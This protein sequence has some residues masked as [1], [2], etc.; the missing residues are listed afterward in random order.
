MSNP[1]IEYQLAGTAEPLPPLQGR[2]ILVHLVVNVEHW[3]FDKPMPRKLLGS[4]HGQNN[5]PDI[6]N[7]SWVEYGMRVGL[8][9]LLRALGQRGLP[10]SASMNAS[11]IEH[12]RPAAEAIV[13]AGWELIGHGMTQQTL[14]AS[15]DE[16]SVIVQTLDTMEA[17]TGRRPRGWLGPGLAETMQTPDILSAEGV[18][19]VCDWVI[20]DLPVW[21]SAQPR[22][23]VA[24]PYTLELND[25][26]LYA[27][28]WYPASE[29]E[30]RLESTL[31]LFERECAQHPL[32]LTVALHPH[33]I[34][35]PHRF[36]AF[37]R[38]LDRLQASPHT[39]FVNGS[40]MCDWFLAARSIS[41]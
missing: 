17:F 37:E 27:A 24:L 19:Y 20:D 14:H 5:I 32:V 29:Y 2:R 28:Q 33:L 30:R 18:D 34:G 12:Y 26:V 35:V 39:I 38:M 15:P 10:A 41:S 23:L 6:P 36:A 3:S 16:K 8:A 22:P 4:P 13:A 31:E 25:S 7:Y 11:V 40:Q 9:R 21:L 1:R